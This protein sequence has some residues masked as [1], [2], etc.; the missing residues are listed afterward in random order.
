MSN[1]VSKI[2]YCSDSAVGGY[3]I[4][5]LLCLLTAVVTTIILIFHK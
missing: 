4:Y 1:S 2:V 5:K 3:A